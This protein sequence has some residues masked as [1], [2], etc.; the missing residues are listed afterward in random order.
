MERTR[1]SI[2]C[3]G[4]DSEVG[5]LRPVATVAARDWKAAEDR[6]PT[7]RLTMDVAGFSANSSRRCAPGW[8]VDAHHATVRGPFQRRSVYCGARGPRATARR[9]P[10][11]PRAMPASL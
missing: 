9:H 2:R 3:A 8:P 6:D 10:T 5:Y 1:R 11:S 7:G 4:V